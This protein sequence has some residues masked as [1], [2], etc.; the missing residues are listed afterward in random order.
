MKGD[1][2]KIDEYQDD[3][4]VDEGASAAEEKMAAK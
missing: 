4:I 3:Q 2:F 1:S